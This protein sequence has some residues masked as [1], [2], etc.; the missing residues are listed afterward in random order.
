MTDETMDDEIVV[1]TIPWH[2]IEAV[3]HSEEEFDGIL[4]DKDEDGTTVVYYPGSL[5][6]FHLFLLSLAHAMGPVLEPE[7][8]S[9]HQ[10]YHALAELTMDMPLPVP[11]T[12]EGDE[13][14]SCKLPNVHI[15]GLPIETEE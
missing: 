5:W 14:F 6:A 4:F 3:L 15:D 7:R 9:F 8:D 1:H 12:K 2:V 10:I 13:Y 11:D